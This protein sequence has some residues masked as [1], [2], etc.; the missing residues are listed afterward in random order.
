MSGSILPLEKRT[1]RFWDFV[2]RIA[3]TYLFAVTAVHA[4]SPNPAGGHFET[5][6][7]LTSEMQLAAAR[8]DRLRATLIQG[9]L[10]RGDFRDGDRIVVRIESS[11]GFSDTLTVQTG[12]RL[13]LR[14][15]GEVSLEGVLRSELVSKLTTHLA[16]FLRD[17]VVHATPLVRIGILGSVSRPGY[18]Y[19][20]AEI[21]LTDV[22]MEAG[23]PT[24][25]ADLSKTEVRRGTNVIV[26][27]RNTQLAMT[28]GYSVDML[29]L[30]AGDA[31][32][33]GRKSQ[34]NWVMAVSTAATIVGLLIA[35]KH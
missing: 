24:A 32:E 11:A 30:S 2:R 20:S 8:G 19:T 12:K 10:D 31:I 22:L 17:P 13:D 21:P 34:F 18:Y 15:L 27:T 23:G 33:V 4:Q 1:T 28:Q 9:R 6:D 35:V 14:Q 25:D 3:I 29:H 16:R 5:R 26:D 7:E